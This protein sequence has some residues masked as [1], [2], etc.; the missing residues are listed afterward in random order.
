MGSRAIFNPPIPLNAPIP[1]N[2]AAPAP[3]RSDSELAAAALAWATRGGRGGALSREVATV[4]RRRGRRRLAFAASGAALVLLGALWLV[5]GRARVA[6]VPAAVAA[7]PN[8][9]A[10]T[11]GSRAELRAG[12]RIEADFG[13]TVRRVTL[14]EGEAYFAV[15]K[16]PARPFIVVARGVEVRAVGTE[17]SV[18]LTAGRVEVIVTEGRVAVGRSATT[19]AAPRA[20]AS[21]GTGERVV[22]DSAV[23]VPP[24]VGKI[25][26]IEV[27]TEHAWR[28]PRLEL[29]GTPLGEV[30][31]SFNR[32]GSVRLALDP[33][34]TDLRLG[35][36]LRA[37]NTAALLRLLQDEFGIVAE[38]RDGV[39]RL[40]RR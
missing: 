1:K 22:V 5:P 19:V 25:S 31:A 37:D 4:R 12:A 18:D 33:A 29:A 15:A 28:V 6:P 11:D 8:V 20:L 3:A 30:V 24:H 9:Q 10:L 36:A 23:S 39:L 13:P 7:A 34:L 38:E 35:G 21:L 40:H 32:H 14:L 17:F 27:A 16:D 2:S 26:A